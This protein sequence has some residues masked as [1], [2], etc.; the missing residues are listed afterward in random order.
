MQRAKKLL[1]GLRIHHLGFGF[2]WTVTFVVL[3]GFQPSRE[4]SVFW[5]G[6]TLAEQVLMPLAVGVLGFLCARRE[7]PH[8]TAGAA[9]FLLSGAALLYFL[10]FHL[11]EGTAALAIVAGLL[12]G[13]ACALFFLLWELFYVTEGQQR[14]LI[15]IPL[16]AAMS[17]G[18]YLQC[19]FY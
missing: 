9:C 1:K 18:L 16:S 6:Y 7:L 4:L 8:W 19:P 12:M 11:G 13:I 3:S 5:Q 14:A 2:F 10:V 17:V 15:C